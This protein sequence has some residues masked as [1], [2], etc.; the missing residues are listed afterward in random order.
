MGSFGC[1]V[2][3]TDRSAVLFGMLLVSA[4]CTTTQ[5]PVSTPDAAFAAG[6][7]LPVGEG[8]EILITECLNCHEL[9]SLELFKD[10]YDRDLWRSLVIS[11]RANGAEV[12]DA[13]VDVLSEYLARHFG[14]Q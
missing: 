8:R 14:T 3:R 12:D 5:Q 6:V 13:E 7:E 11:M 10:F 1:Q 2:R 9:A 4:A